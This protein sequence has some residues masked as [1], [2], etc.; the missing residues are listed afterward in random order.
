LKLHFF[1]LDVALGAVASSLFFGQLFHVS[2]PQHAPTFTVL[3]L[4]VWWLYLFDHLLDTRGSEVSATS[5]HELIAKYRLPVGVFWTVLSFFIFFKLLKL[6]APV[7]KCGFALA[8]SAMLYFFLTPH[9]PFLKEIAAA[10]LYT[11][12]ILIPFSQDLHPAQLLHYWQPLIIFFLTVLTNLFLFSKNDIKTDKADGKSS[13]SV[14]LGIRKINF[15]TA[16]L[17]ILNFLLLA[18]L[19]LNQSYPRIIGFV[20]LL[21]NLTMLALFFF[22][23]NKNEAFR[24]LGDGI[25]FI[26]LLIFKF[27]NY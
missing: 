26:P 9:L 21:M 6:P 23:K 5:R 12:G 7:L 22:W 18:S 3:G 11:C 19:F 8:L 17:F 27:S 4:C 1:S 2:L 24:F 15:V 10:F 25:F 16:C 14:I 20:F 13:L